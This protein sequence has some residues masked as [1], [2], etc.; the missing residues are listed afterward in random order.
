MFELIHGNPNSFMD[1]LRQLPVQPRRDAWVEVNLGA[2]EEN[3]RLIRRLIP[4]NIEL[5]A[6]VKA[7]AYGHGAAMVLPTLE[8]SGVKMAGVASMDEAIHLR[9]SGIRMPVLVL[10]GVPDWT[11]RYA[12]REDIRLSI[13]DE[14]H[15][16]ILSRA[17]MHETRPFKVHVK[18]DTGMH[19]IGIPWEKAAPFIADCRKLDF[20]EV[21]GMFSHFA[22]STDSP[23]RALQLERWAAVRHAV[24]PLPH[25]V[26]ISNSLHALEPGVFQSPYSN[27]FGNNLARLGLAFFGYGLPSGHAEGDRLKPVLGLKARILHIQEVAAGTGISYGH[28]HHTRPLLTGA[29]SRIA[30]VPLGYADGVPRCLSNKIEGLLAGRRV[31]QVGTI[32]MDQM[33]F[34][35][36]AVPEALIGDSITLLGWE[37]PEGQTLWLDE[38][39]RH[40]GTIEYELMCALRVRLPKT[41]IR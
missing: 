25:Y 41:Y 27:G 28:T 29:L 35:I 24:N 19:R 33:M 26:H 23:S 14:H 15:L 34:D 13:F 31:P 20:I 39:A 5:M 30:T 3:A 18:I 9:Q 1:S 32:T 4:E 7:D 6:I 40:A 2:L 10:G 38:W 11:V 8:A 12:A 22:D 36:S 21:E 17:A 16:D 37:E